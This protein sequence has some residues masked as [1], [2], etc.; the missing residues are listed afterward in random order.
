VTATD[1]VLL[2]P[3]YAW[4]CPGCGHRQAAPAAPLPEDRAPQSL[5]RTLRRQWQVPPGEPLPQRLLYTPPTEVTCG[6]CNNTFFAHRGELDL[7]D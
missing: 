1:T 7:E 6:G 5:V 4:V 2:E 3:A